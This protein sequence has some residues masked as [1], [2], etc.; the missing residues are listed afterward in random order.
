MNASTGELPQF[1]SGE[2]SDGAADAVLKRFTELLLTG[3]ISGRVSG[4]NDQ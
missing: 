3:G 4:L 1:F 2:T